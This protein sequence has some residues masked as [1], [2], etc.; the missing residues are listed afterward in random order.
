MKWRAVGEYWKGAAY[1]PRRWQA[2]CLPVAIAELGTKQ[3]VVVQAVMG[4][5]KTYLIAELVRSAVLEEGEHIIITTPTQRLVEQL[6]AALVERIGLAQVGR[7]YGR[8]K[9]IHAPVIVACS[10]SV[11]RL[12]MELNSWGGRR[13]AV[14]ISDEVHRTECDQIKQAYESLNPE[15][16]IG[17]TATPWRGSR[18]E[19]LS[20]WS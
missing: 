13:C 12:A 19:E 11:P 1:P 14:W 7:Y 16:A 8:A 9:N 10:P 15:R 5:G 4:S 18:T 2:A 17:F 20:L 6:T 3:P